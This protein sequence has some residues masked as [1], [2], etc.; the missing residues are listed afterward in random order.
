MPEHPLARRVYE[1]FTRR[2]YTLATA[3]SCTGGLIGHLV[4]S[5]P[6]CS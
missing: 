5:V 6:G 4:T 2:R 1:S 3:E